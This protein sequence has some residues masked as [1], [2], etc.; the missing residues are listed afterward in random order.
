MKTEEMDFRDFT[1]VDAGYACEVEIARSDSYSVSITA[2]D[3][4][5]KS[6][7][8]DK[9]GGTL[10]IRRSLSSLRGLIPGTF[11]AKITM[12]VLDRLELSGASKGTVSGFSSQGD[13][14]ANLKGASSLAIS[15]MSAGD[16]KFKLAGAS[17]LTGQVKGADAGFDL[18]GASRVELEGSASNTV[19]DAAGASHVD[20]AGFH[21]YGAKIRLSG[22]SHTTLNIDGQLDANLS[23]ASKLYWLGKPIMGDIKMAG[24]STISS[25]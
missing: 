15:N 21:I 2:G 23:G 5:I 11:Q 6:V 1:S 19:I 13:F 18:S 10:R 20:L 14:I 16:M 24:A 9:Q 17:K 3:N 25:E 12:P 7:K 8:V 22:A 4:L